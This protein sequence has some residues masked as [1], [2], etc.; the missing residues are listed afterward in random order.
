[1]EHSYQY[2][3]VRKTPSGVQTNGT[4]SCRFGNKNLNENNDDSCGVFAEWIWDGNRLTVRND[5]SGYYPL[6][7]YANSTVI[8]VSNSLIKLVALGAPTNYDKDAL[9]VFCRCGFFLAEQ[10]P[11]KQIR[12][13]PPNATLEW[14]DGQ[15][16]IKGGIRITKAQK[17][18]RKAAVEGYIDLF[19]QAIKR[20]RPA[21]EEFIIPLTGGRDSRQILLEL[22]RQAVLPKLCVT[23][24]DRRDVVVAK[25]LVDRLNL[26]H[27]IITGDQSWME[28]VWRKNIATHFCALEH[29]WLMMLG[30][31]L[32]ANCR[33]S[34]DGTGVGIL[35][36]SEL[37][38]LELLDLYEASRLDEIAEWL[39][40]TAGPPERFLRLLPEKYG[41]IA[42]GRNRAIELFAD[43]LR[44]HSFAA[45]PLTSFNF[46]NW[47]RRAI[48]LSPFGIQ[49]R[50]PRIN[51]PFLDKDLYDFVSSFIPS[52]I[53][54]QEPQSEAIKKAFPEYADIPFY[55][56]L[57]K[58]KQ[59]K[60]GIF[61]RC[62]NALDKFLMV[63]KHCPAN[64]PVVCRTYMQNKQLALPARNRAMQ[65]N[66]LLYLS[67]L[68]YCSK[69]KRAENM[70]SDYHKLE[71]LNL[72]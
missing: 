58:E 20:C 46:W 10:T 19:R 40:D 33:E 50:V 52:L 39:F 2:L 41:F 23:C 44:R 72:N 70:L 17:L 68:N 66:A 3:Q 60:S 55:N 54:E 18:T 7:Y 1:M 30:D 42:A 62:R 48:A 14:H 49:N 22:N 8:M 45:N 13:L 21:S 6:F 28:Y 27:H 34:F 31:Y 61:T 51:T 43:E 71:Y 47:N 65:Q 57:P 32:L 53:L 24:G 64:L 69:K 63:A 38:T 37:F 16:S 12:T 5:Y 36:R 26:N 15:L 4:V 56:E 25:M 35:T 11:F 29:T 67:Q 9:S 59:N